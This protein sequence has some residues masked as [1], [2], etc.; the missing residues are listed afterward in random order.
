VAASTRLNRKQHGYPDE[1]RKQVVQM[2]VDGMNLRHIAR[3]LGIHHRT[4]SLWVQASAARITVV[5]VPEEVQTAE[6]DELFTYIGH[7]KTG[8]TSSRS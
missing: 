2:Y 1:M 3:H 8:S 5:P 7:K 4:V 6:V